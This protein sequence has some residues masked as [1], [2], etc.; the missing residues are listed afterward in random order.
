MQE[1]SRAG[2]LRVGAVAGAAA[3]GGALLHGAASGAPRG[4]AALD[5][6]VLAF[7]LRIEYLQQAFYADALAHAGLKGELRDFAETALGHEREHV[8]LLKH[9]LGGGAPKPQN[10]AFGTATRSEESFARAARELEDLTVLAYN[11]GAPSLTAA[12]LAQAGRIVSVEARHA[13]WIRDISGTNP[14]PDATEP[15]VSPAEVQHRLNRLGF[16]Q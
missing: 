15:V 13:S 11:A 14:A 7:A 6:K 10:F 16:T 3:A 5:A 8:A 1:I 2:L 9:A 12:T 4:S